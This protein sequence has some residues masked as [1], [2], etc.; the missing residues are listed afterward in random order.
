[1]K[2]M[3]IY[4]EHVPDQFGVRG[5]FGG[6]VVGNNAGPMGR[7]TV[8]Q[9]L[10]Y[11][12]PQDRHQVPAAIATTSSGIGP[13]TGTSTAAAMAMRQSTAPT[14][15]ITAPVTGSSAAASF[16]AR[17]A[18]KLNLSSKKKRK[19]SI[20]IMNTPEPPIMMMQPPEQPIFPTN[21]SSII[22]RNPPPAP[23]SL[24]RNVN[25]VKEHPG[26]GKVKVMLRVIPSGNPCDT[27]TFVTVDTKKKQVTLFDPSFLTGHVSTAGRRAG[28]AA[29]KMFAFDAV[30]PH[31]ASQAE[32]CAG[33]VADTVQAVVNG[34]D[35][36]L[37]CYGHAHLGKT[38][39]MIGSDES[40]HKIGVIP[41][42]IAWLFKLINEKKE[43][44]STRF[45]VR[46]SAVEVYGKQEKL[47]DLLIE[48]ANGSNNGCGT[49]P[50]LYLQEDPICGVQLLNQNEL[51]APTAEKAAFYLDAAI[52]TRL[53]KGKNEEAHDGRYSHMLFTLHVYQYRI[54]KSGK[55]GVIGGRSRL[56]LI[57]L[58]SGDRGGGRAANGAALSF[59]ALGNVILAVLNGQK[60]IPNRDSMLTR[61]LR[62][63]MGSL[64]CRTVMIAHASA[65]LN[66]YAETLGTIQ[67]ASRIHRM[68][69]KKSNYSGTSSSGGD[70]S[71]DEG[72][73]RRR[74]Y[75]PPANNGVC[76][77]DAVNQ[78]DPEYISSSEQSCDTVIYVG[79]DG[80]A[81]SDRELTDN[82]GPPTSLPILKGMSS[83]EDDRCG[84]SSDRDIDE[85]RWA[86]ADSTNEMSG[87]DTDGGSDA[88]SRTTKSLFNKGAKSSK[89]SSKS[90]IPKLSSSPKRKPS[91]QSKKAPPLPPK[92]SDSTKESLNRKKAAKDALSN[93]KAKVNRHSS[94]KKLTHDPKVNGISGP[95]RPQ[96]F[97]S[98]L[99]PPSAIH[100]PKPLP[101]PKPITVPRPK[102]FISCSD[103]EAENYM[104]QERRNVG[105]SF[106]LVEDEDDDM[107]EELEHRPS[108]KSA[109]DGEL[110]D[111]STSE[112]E[113]DE[114]ALA[115]LA[116]MPLAPNGRGNLSPVLEIDDAASEKGE[117]CQTK[118]NGD[119][120]DDDDELT[121]ALRNADANFTTQAANLAE[122]P[123]VETPSAVEALPIVL[124]PRVERL[125]SPTALKKAGIDAECLMRTIHSLEG[126]SEFLDKPISEISEDDISSLACSEQDTLSYVSRDTEDVTSVTD[127]SI[128]DLP[129]GSE[130]MCCIKELGRRSL[131]SYSENYSISFNGASVDACLN[132][133]LLLL[134]HDERNKLG[135]GNYV[136]SDDESEIADGSSRP[137]RS[138][139]QSEKDTFDS[140]SMAARDIEAIKQLYVISNMSNENLSIDDDISEVNVPNLSF[141]E[142]YLQDEPSVVT[143][144]TINNDEQVVMREKH[145][146][147]DDLDH[148][149]RRLS[150]IS[151]ATDAT[152][153]TASRPASFADQDDMTLIGECNYED[154]KNE[155]TSPNTI[156]LINSL[157]NLHMDA[158][159]HSNGFIRPQWYQNSPYGNTAEETGRT[160][161]TPSSSETSPVWLRMN[162]PVSS[163]TEQ[164]GKQ[165]QSSSG[166]PRNGC[167]NRVVS[168]LDTNAILPNGIRQNLPARLLTEVLSNSS[169]ASFY[170]SPQHQATVASVQARNVHL[171][172]QPSP[173]ILS[174]AIQ[175]AKHQMAVRN[176]MPKIQCLADLEKLYGIDIRKPDGA[177]TEDVKSE[178]IPAD[179][180]VF[181]GGKGFDISSMERPPAIGACSAP[182]FEVEMNPY[183]L[184]EY[185][186]ALLSGETKETVAMVHQPPK[187]TVSEART[188]RLVSRKESGQSEASSISK[189]SDL[190]VQS[191]PVTRLPQPS[192]H[193]TP[194]K[195]SAATKLS[196]RT[197]KPP[198]KSRE[199]NHPGSKSAPTS[200]KKT[201]QTS[202]I[203]Q[204]PQANPRSQT[205]KSSALPVRKSLSKSAPSLSRTNQ[206][207]TKI[208]ITTVTSVDGTSDPAPSMR[209]ANNNIAQLQPGSRLTN[210][211]DSSNDS[212]IASSENVTNSKP[213]ILSPYSTVTKP[214]TTKSSSSGH[215]SDN[216][217][218][219]SD[220]VPASKGIRRVNGAS[221]TSSGYE[222]MLRDSE[223]TASCSSAHDSLSEGSCGRVKGSKL[224]R[225]KF[226]GARRSRSVPRS[227]AS[228]CGPSTGSSKSSRWK[229]LPPRP[230]LPNKEGVELKVYEVDDPHR[231]QQQRPDTIKDTS[232]VINSKSPSKSSNKSPSK[233]PKKA[234]DTNT[235]SSS[236]SNGAPPKPERYERAARPS[237]TCE[238]ASGSS[239]S[240]IQSRHRE[241]R[242]QLALAEAQLQEGEGQCPFELHV[243]E[244]VESQFGELA[245]SPME[246]ETAR[247]EERLINCRA[248]LAMIKCLNLLCCSPK[249]HKPSPT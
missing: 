167:T 199:E 113:P 77:T 141:G 228:D 214:R 130:A 24:L 111:N 64:S 174:A 208:P 61:L 45:S 41:S 95:D 139:R 87:R 33:S 207:S 150:C 182:P 65:A 217:S 60:H 159:K 8:P 247:L 18:Q 185:D 50:A 14:N 101:K 4:I 248:H 7:T 181:D 19:G 29:P 42:A 80:C 198:P 1:M 89:L 235:L 51:R 151:D 59:S 38:Y 92:R 172:Q 16:F 204:K 72:R 15:T 98:N 146:A 190:T 192:H 157:Q 102:A 136:Y 178:P 191:C 57:D 143:Y 212:G 44:T 187:V 194:S 195:S 97:P 12:P 160:G 169:P 117:E 230:I 173:R 161:Y 46:V 62:E 227:S 200:S 6:G 94:E 215:G 188:K 52:A 232:V 88:E 31:D 166:V 211:S 234:C 93:G 48:Q 73:I 196:S 221:G 145:L 144:M 39:T 105:R 53:T 128:D 96:N 147:L 202:R 238:E 2:N 125:L 69:K 55:G 177:A 140:F 66:N 176:D 78:S 189:G 242:A 119:I 183:F 246:E 114:D 233:S 201:A 245:P 123:V 168:H 63:A 152:F 193:G 241:L 84:S 36:C 229:D 104:S 21:F 13:V 49:S 186:D 99:K 58:G 122:N 90:L 23:P 155:P 68:R 237:E 30:F 210:S 184:Q 17:A 70:S 109:S 219:F 240:L 106:L 225:K 153:S 148:P 203:P 197:G 213:A 81:L 27:A 25:R 131:D 216:S 163:S 83:S 118:V 249:R 22:L 67:N 107:N 11:I 206:T 223:N 156:N 133:P 34:A 162:I 75:A 158:M 220:S 54:D 165:G 124:S 171:S 91:D 239:S 154:S 179:H 26:V 120:E 5:N 3:E 28:V 82:E 137:R 170:N 243:L 129:M 37:F 218:T 138:E 85:F 142:S 127:M 175:S 180:H 100:K 47:R 236:G 9:S 71:C 205:P 134:G 121:A 149:L 35:G 226:G 231:I 110:K 20:P 56:H 164:K 126:L 108:G 86:N 103:T 132:E 74:R 76:V 224:P 209:N 79:P 32:V 43:K 244:E 112:D 10:T 115:A 40:V 222:S 135:L 116:G